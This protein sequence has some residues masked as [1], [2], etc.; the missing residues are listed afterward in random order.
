MSAQ[1]EEPVTISRAIST[2]TI[3]ITIIPAAMTVATPVATAV[4]PVSPENRGGA[5]V[6]RR[7]ERGGTELDKVSSAEQ[8]AGRASH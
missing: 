4:S 6:P 1:H 5:S 8:Q 7:K 3:T 2:I